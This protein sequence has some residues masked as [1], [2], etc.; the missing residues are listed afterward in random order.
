MHLSFVQPH[1]PLVPLD[2]YFQRYLNK[3]IPDATLGD[4]CP[5][6]QGQSRPANAAT[7][8]FDPGIIRRATAGYYALINHIDDCLAAL[9]DQWRGYGSPDAN[10]PLYIIFSSDHGEMLG[11]HQL[12]RKSLGYEASANVPFFIS[13][14]PKGPD[15]PS[16]SD[17]LVCWEDIAP[18]ILD[19]AGVDIHPSMEGHS[20]KPILEGNAFRSSRDHI[21]GQCGGGHHNL[22]I[23]TQEWKYLWFP[24]TNEEQLF[25]LKEDPTES[26]DL[27]G[28]HSQI[29]AMR[30]LMHEHTKNRDDLEYDHSQLQPCRNQPPKIFWP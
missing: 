9:L 15:N 27:S 11:D 24:K 30:D 21:F 5:Q 3:D 13:G 7:G 10:D 20:L 19:L 25:H 12:F 18:T 4:W 14:H 23:V 6:Y 1:P 2:H 28:D 26:H 17:E 22:W 29:Q 8:P 16:Q